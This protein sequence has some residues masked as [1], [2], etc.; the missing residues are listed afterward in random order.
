MGAA[1]ESEERS[2]LHHDNAIGPG[3]ALRFGS[4]SD[5]STRYIGGMSIKSPFP[6]LDPYLQKH[7][8]DVHHSFIQYSRDAL[9][10]HLPD[11]LLSRVE[12]RVFVEEFGE[13][14]RSIAPDIHIAEWRPGNGHSQSEGVSGVALAESRVFTFEDEEITEGFIE[15]REA[16][17]GKLVTVIEFLSPANK[18]GGNGTD[19]YLE[20]QTEVMQSGTS[21]VEID[22]IRGGKR[23]LAMS[24]TSV[25]HEWRHDGLALIRKG[26]EGTQFELFR[27]PL[28]RSLGHLPIPLRRHEFPIYLDLQAIH[29]E[30]FRKG[31]Y[32]RLDY[33]EPPE[34][35]LSADDEAWAS[36][37]LIAAGKR[38]PVAAHL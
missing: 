7:W 26:W 15:I 27:F 13:R 19:K 20:K 12:E 14:R 10:E 11:G 29:D 5:I 23:I 32:D 1:L 25:P 28:R 8:G 18:A 16:N 34:P 35:P 36:G 37:I 9:Q 30:C 33:S 4:D 2:F 6:G 31:R 21:L 24:G 17:G 3:T 22:L 38:A